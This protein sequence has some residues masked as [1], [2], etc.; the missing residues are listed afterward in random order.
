MPAIP[1][2]S[3][4]EIRELYAAGRDPGSLVSRRV[5]AYIREKGLYR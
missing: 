4:T 5:G 3:S 1:A 2:V